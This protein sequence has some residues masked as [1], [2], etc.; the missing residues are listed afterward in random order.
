MSTAKV[1]VSGSRSEVRQATVDREAR[2]PVLE[3][4]LPARVVATMV[5]VKVQTL[6][7]WRYQGRGPRGWIRLSATLV[8]YPAS[9]VT[10]F[11]AER[12]AKKGGEGR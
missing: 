2:R 10:A 4:R 6:A 1:E 7:K 8:V 3:E 11:L 9:E 5:G 12:A